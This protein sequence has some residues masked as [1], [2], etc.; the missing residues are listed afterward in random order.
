MEE[1]RNLELPIQNILAILGGKYEKLETVVMLGE[2]EE[3]DGGIF[4]YEIGYYSY[5]DSGFYQ[6]FHTERYTEEEFEDIVIEATLRVVE[7]KIPEENADVE[8][9]AR[10]EIAELG[11]GTS[12]M[13]KKSHG[14]S[15]EYMAE[16]K[17]QLLER[18][19]R[20]IEE[21]WNFNFSDIYSY[22]VRL[23]CAEYGFKQI[24]FSA[25]FSVDGWSQLR[26]ESAGFRAERNPKYVKL[27]QAIQDKF[28]TATHGD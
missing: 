19:Q 2:D 1:L 20:E 15:D 10:H 22:V 17:A 12:Y 4:F 11:D 18:H 5:E 26:E 21:G 13:L 16:R 24:K 23:L 14:E 9:Y 7:A 28:G 25:R 27:S 8:R 3:P 6:F